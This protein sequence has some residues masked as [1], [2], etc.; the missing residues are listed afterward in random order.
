MKENTPVL[1]FLLGRCFHYIPQIL[2]FLTLTYLYCM[3]EWQ[4]Q[5][6]RKRSLFG[7]TQMAQ[8]LAPKRYIIIMNQVHEM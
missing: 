8:S 5:K 2:P 1:I 4:S 3:G 7:S 6:P